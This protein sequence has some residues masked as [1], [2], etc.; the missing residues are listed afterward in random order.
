MSDS[1]CEDN[2]FLDSMELIHDDLYAWFTHLFPTI[3]FH[4]SNADNTI[5]LAAIADDG[6]ARMIAA[7][8]YWAN[9]I[10]PSNVYFRI[11]RAYT[12]RADIPLIQ[13]GTHVPAA[14]N[15]ELTF[16]GTDTSRGVLHATEY[17]PLTRETVER[18]I[19]ETSTW[20]H[21]AHCLREWLLVEP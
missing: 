6:T 16:T 9:P 7:G 13:A 2:T 4:T 1:D 5:E 10:P 17:N 21:V 18:F 8:F 11:S 20:K 12:S 3:T 15:H 19:C 14:V